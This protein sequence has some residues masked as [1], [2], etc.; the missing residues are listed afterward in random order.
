[1]FAASSSSMPAAKPKTYRRYT[2]EQR[3]NSV[4]AVAAN[5]GNVQR[6]GEATLHILEDSRTV[7]QITVVPLENVIRP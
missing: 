3:A 1:M 4:A 5:G 7:V 6:T 2:D